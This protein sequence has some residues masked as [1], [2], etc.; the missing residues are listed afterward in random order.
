MRGWPLEKQ[1]RFKAA[2]LD[3]CRVLKFDSKE[4]GGGAVLGDHLY[5]AQHIMIDAIFNGLGDGIHDFKCLKSRQLGISTLTRAFVLFWLGMHDGL[6]GLL[7]FDT[8]ANK[9][10]ARGELVSMLTQLPAVYAFPRIKSD[11]R[12]GLTL[13]NG[14]Q[15]LFRAAG[16]KKGDSNKGLGTSLGVNLIH[17]SE[18]CLWKSDAGVK[19]LLPTLSKTFPNRLFIWESPLDLATPI[20]TPAGWTTMGGLKEG[21]RVFDGQGNE[22]SVV[23]LSPIFNDRKCFEI[24]FSNGDSVVADACHKWQVEVRRYPANQQWKTAVVRTDELD[25]ENHRISVARPLSGPNAD[26]PIDPYLLGFWLGDGRSDGPR[27][28]TGDADVAEV[29]KLFEKRGLRLGPISKPDWRV[30][31]FNVEGHRSVF[32]HLNLLN[33]KHI[34]AVYLRASESQRRELLAGLMDSD[35]YIDPETLQCNFSNTNMRLLDDVAELLSSLGIKF[36]RSCFSEEGATRKFPDGKVR[37]C[38]RAERLVFNEDP[39]LKVFNLRRKA[40]VH[41]ARAGKKTPFTWRKSKWLKIVSIVEVASRPVR[42]IEVDSPSH[43]FLVGKTMI[44]THNTA[45]GYGLWYDMWKRAEA[46]TLAQ[47]TLFIGWWAK[48]DQRL[49]R[50][51]PGFFKYG[52]AA[53]TEWEAERIAAVKRLYGFEITQ[54]QLAWWRWQ[55]DPEG[56]HPDDHDPEFLQHQ[57]FCAEDAFQLTG[58]N[59]FSPERLKECMRDCAEPQ[60]L[61]RFYAGADFF[62]S[63]WERAR[64]PRDA[65]L[66]VWEE[67]VDK[68]YY[69]ISADPAFGRKKENNHAAV[70]V[71]RA[72]ADRLVQVAEYANSEIPTHQFAWVIASLMAHYSQGPQGDFGNDALLIFEVNGPGE[73]V[74]NELRGLR[75]QVESVL[76]RKEAKERGLANMFNAVRQ[77]IRTRPDSFGESKSLHWNTNTQNK[78]AIFE[79]LRDFM[80][81]RH[82]VLR[83]AE[84][85]EEMRGVVRDG[86]SI[87]AEGRARDDRTFACALAVRAWEDRMRGPMARQGLTFARDEESRRLSPLDRYSLFVQSQIDNM[88]KRKRL[89]HFEAQRS[90][91]YRAWRYK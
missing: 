73:A 65:Q 50:G 55:A 24:K 63:S 3:F 37:S 9:N 54:E 42:C 48:E 11:N 38:R 16:V 4:L 59:F 18:M 75:T 66:K 23:G 47:R 1:L 56:K 77:Y 43:L 14:S 60:S 21:D 80:T 12:Y 15:I 8:D 29:R 53:P 19:S 28:T 32:K 10:N 33:N 34:P 57:P 61:H 27:I 83:S 25:V 20:P 85:L 72:Y 89:E 41:E 90:A 13:D 70:Q 17:A 62:N 76:S 35:G 39:A 71:F 6:R 88:M 22:C 44:P 5:L 52:T 68:A 46:D 45:M 64:S 91:A 82:V 74:L 78:L 81:A 79:R 7:I 31:V 40:C 30:P 58:S 51:T 87:G 69:V 86:D 26:L 49:E 2:F 36:K 67:P 84:L